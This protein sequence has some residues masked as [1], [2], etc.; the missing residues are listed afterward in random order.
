MASV[1]ILDLS[2]LSNR[3]LGNATEPCGG[4]NRL[5]LFNTTV[6]AGGVG[7]YVNPGVNGFRSLGCY[8]YAHLDCSEHSSLASV[9]RTNLRMID[10]IA[11]CL[12]ISLILTHG[13]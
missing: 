12:A 10:L 7:P 9:A 8:R 1:D 2:H 5:T 6:P 13:K 4:P 3:K 11:S